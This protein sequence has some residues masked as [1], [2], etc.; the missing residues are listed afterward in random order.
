MAAKTDS[1][2]IAFKGWIHFKQ[3]SGYGTAKW[4]KVRQFTNQ[5]GDDEQFLPRKRSPKFNH[6]ESK[7]Q[8]TVLRSAKAC[9]A[10]SQAFRCAEYTR[11]FWCFLG[12]MS[13]IL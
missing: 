8:T 6:G 2:A 13:F 5:S 7:A 10:P 1:V 4:N 9:I 3:I 12:I 11:I